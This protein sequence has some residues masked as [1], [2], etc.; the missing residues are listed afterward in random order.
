MFKSSTLQSLNIFG[1][2]EGREFE[3]Q[4]LEVIGINGKRFGTMNW[5]QPSATVPTRSNQ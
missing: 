4:S 3:L 2:C 1:L 5:A